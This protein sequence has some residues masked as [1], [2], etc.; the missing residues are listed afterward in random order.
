M[1]R[2]VHNRYAAMKLLLVAA[3]V[4]MAIALPIGQPAK[5]ADEVT[6]S[7]GWWSN[8]PTGDE[9]H[10]KW[11]DEFEKANPG[12][13]VNSEILPWGSY[14]DKVQTTTAG[15]NAYD[16]I[17]M[18]S[19]FAAT[20]MDNGVLLDLKTFKDYDEVAKR[21]NPNALSIFSWNDTQYGMPVGMAVRVLGYN[22][23]LFDKAGVEY[24]DPTRPLTV[25]QLIEMAKKLTIE[26]DGKVVQY[27]WNPNNS[28]PWYGFIAS[29][30][31]QMYDSW[32]N[33]TKVMV[34]DEK[35]IAGLKR[36]KQLVDA[37]VVP[38]LAEFTGNEWGDG[39]LA[40]LRT[41]KVAMADLGPWNFADIM[42]DKLNIGTTIYPVGE[43]GQESYLTSGSNG[44]TIS[45]DSKHAEAAW[46][47]IK[48]MTEKENQLAYAK[49][50]DIPANTE[51][52]DAIDT[53]LQPSEY[54]PT[55]KA[56][57]EGF[58]PGVMS[59]KSE[60]GSKM[61]EIMRDMTEGNLTPE[62]AAEQMEIQGNEILES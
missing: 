48:W 28:E 12:I 38:P 18:C 26:K 45:K 55:L 20:Y 50:S 17:G 31:G 7:Y 1:Q 30:G 25:D 3:I 39:G 14:W 19:C 40:S 57:L 6:I 51:A 43:E 59:T 35:G 29:E 36:L 44:Y 42:K 4:L 11:L 16:V 13:K 41:G 21:M 32:V 10:R 56:Q 23:D 2:N 52:F 33:P 47:F 62:E 46:A 34:N 27:M 15:G 61:F 37:K 8:G 53:F 60:L 54:V 22:K 58:R 9:N 49:W 5:A 24:P